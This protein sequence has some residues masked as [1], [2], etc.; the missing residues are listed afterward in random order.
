[1]SVMYT[2]LLDCQH[3]HL[4]AHE[5]D[6]AK[7]AFL[8]HT[9]EERVRLLSVMPVSEAVGVL[10]CC[11]LALVRELLDALTE[12]GDTVRSR[13]IA[14]DLGLIS[15]EIEP[16]GDYLT[17]SVMNHVRQRIGW[18]V[19][20]ALL[21]ILSGL[22]ISHY[23]DTIT[24][25]VLLAIYMPVV[26]AAGGNAGSQAATLVVRAMA[27]NEVR[28]SQW[29]AVMWKEVR[30]AIIIAFALAAV[31]MTRV[32]VFSDATSLPA[33]FHLNDIAMAIGTALVIQVTLSTTLGGVLPLVARKLKLDPAV[34]VSPVLASVVDISGMAIYFMTINAWLGLT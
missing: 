9:M 1:M 20:L 14:I 7:N 19:G 5:I 25:L 6:A 29:L 22:I 27:M 18:I 30:V 32:L 12:T 24:Q 23:E 8:I 34:L 2:T 13:Q 21:G 26:A 28:P 4:A 33:G 15:S 3:T 31:I 11:P 16:D 10:N 17:N